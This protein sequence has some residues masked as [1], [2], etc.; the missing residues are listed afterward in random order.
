MSAALA[1]VSPAQDGMSPDTPCSGFRWR[2]APCW[3]RGRAGFDSV[4]VVDAT[5][6]LRAALSGTDAAFVGAPAAGARTLPWNR[7]VSVR[8]LE[9]V[10]GGDADGE[11]RSSQPGDLALAEKRLLGS[12]VKDTEG[13]MSRHFER[14]ISLAVSR[15]LASTSVTPNAMTLFSIAVGLAGALFFL[16]PTRGSEIAGAVLFLLHSILDGC[17]GELAR[18]KFQESRLGR[19]PR[20]LGRQRRARLPC[21]PPWPSDGGAARRRRLAGARPRRQRRRGHARLGGIRRAARAR[22]RGRRPAVHVRD[23]APRTRLSRIAD[24]LARPRLHLPGSC[25]SLAFGKARWFL[26]LAAARSA[27]LL[28]HPRSRIEAAAERPLGRDVP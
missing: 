19:R 23:A 10:R 1:L 7:V 25:Y 3:P 26:V 5:P 9:A 13:F 27:D 16:T 24:M 14:R 21:S 2:A 17:D 12:L 6:G 28:L 4:A 22:E 15:R 8:D 11:P 18:L 20:L